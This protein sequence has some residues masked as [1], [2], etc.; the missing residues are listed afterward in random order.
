M[1]KVLT[2]TETSSNQTNTTNTNIG[3]N[4]SINIMNGIGG[5][6]MTGNSA[7]NIN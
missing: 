7:L 3:S 1:Y 4:G 5:A 6:I 2:V